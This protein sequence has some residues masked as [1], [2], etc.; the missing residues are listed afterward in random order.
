MTT[1]PTDEE[2]R[3]VDLPT[4]GLTHVEAALKDRMA[5]VLPLAATEDGANHWER[6]YGSLARSLHRLLEAADREARVR[7]LDYP[8]G[9]GDRLWHDLDVAAGTDD[10]Y[11][12]TIAYSGGSA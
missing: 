7:V 12:V 5:D 2:T 4:D 9:D 1:A 8:T 11:V 6:E 10:T 3:R